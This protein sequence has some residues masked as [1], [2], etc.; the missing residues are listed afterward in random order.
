MMSQKAG[1]APDGGLVK[2][3]LVELCFSKEGARSSTW[4]PDKTTFTHMYQ[5]HKV[6]TG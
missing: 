1:Y 3:D 4:N 6:Q 2:D 5:G